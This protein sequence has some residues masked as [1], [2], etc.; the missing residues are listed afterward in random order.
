MGYEK[1]S[2]EYEPNPQRDR[3]AEA[4]ERETASLRAELASVKAEQQK[5]VEEYHR[6]TD[7]QINVNAELQERVK[8]LEALIKEASDDNHSTLTL[9]LRHRMKQALAGGSNAKQ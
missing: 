1:Q 5:D 7:G 3:E 2:W 9:S 8:V 6:L 4:L